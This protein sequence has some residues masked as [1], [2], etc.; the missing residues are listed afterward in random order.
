MSATTIPA[1]QKRRYLPA[2]F[3]VIKWETLEPFYKELVNRPLRNADELEKWILDRNELDAVVAEDFAWR[4]IRLTVDSSDTEAKKHYEYAIQEISPRVAPYEHKLNKK[5]VE[6]PFL[7]KL[8]QNRYFI[9]LRGVQKAVELYRETNIPL[10]TEIQLKS[11]EHGRLF[12]E[13]TVEIDGEHMT[14]QKANTILEETDRERRKETY[15]KISQRVADD[16]EKLEAIFDEL[17]AKRDQMA[18]NV[19]FENYRDY[20]FKE[21]GRFDYTVE[22]CLEFHRSI[23]EEIVPLVNKIYTYRKNSLG[24]DALYPWDLSVD[25][26]GKAPLRP[27]QTVDELVQKSIR[28]LSSLE[29]LFGE[30]L[31]I[32]ER[33][34][35]LDL[36]SRKGK[37]PGGYNMPLIMTGVPF[38]FMNA[39]S[40]INDMRTLMHESGHAVHSFLTK[41]IELNSDKRFPS[42]VAELAAMTMELLTMDHWD[43]F[44]ENKEDLQRA[45]IWQLEGLLQLLPWVGTVDKFQHWVYTH[46]KH[47]REERK[48]AWMEIFNQFSAS[49]VDRSELEQYTAYSWHRQLHIFEV[50]FY[51]VEYGM[52]QLG[53]IAIWRRYREEK[54]AA[55]EGYIKALKLGY[56]CT[57]GEIY[58]AAGIEFNF[59]R[60]Y[61]SGLAAFVQE[62]LQKLI[63]M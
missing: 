55:V 5:L 61:V 47:T 15:I 24:V 42:E 18:R 59:S 21:L 57:I 35:H 53:A 40:S 2:S 45:K 48:A 11:K 27:F 34:G 6:S 51:Y 32:M 25:S 50:P 4:Y 54:R 8:D 12:A 10:S 16:R 62:E 38:I 63:E 52:A 43:V 26:M 39:T 28:T 13:M 23:A 22:D 56:T 9:Y 7:S 20:K 31:A 41:D 49:V 37:R 36:D 29:P 60:E 33:M 1:A 44:F 17:V 30:C 58:Q 46:P 19:N 14:L 3:K